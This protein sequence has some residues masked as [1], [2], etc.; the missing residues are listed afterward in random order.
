MSP[1]LIHDLA[2]KIV[3]NPSEVKMEDLIEA[4]QAILDLGYEDELTE[5]QRFILNSYI[6]SGLIATESFFT[7][8]QRE[9]ATTQ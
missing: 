6:E 8:Q 2:M 1:T 5:Q 7:R 4:Y 9:D 3:A